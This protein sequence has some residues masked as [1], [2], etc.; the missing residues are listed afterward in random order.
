M[1]Q[2]KVVIA[3]VLKPVND[4]RMFE[5]L[6]MSLATTNHYDVNIIGFNAKPSKSYSNITFHPIFNFKRISISRILCGLTFYRYLKKI[7]PILIIIT[8][9]ELIWPAVIYKLLHRSKVIYDVQENHFRNL[10]FTNSFPK[11]IRPFLAF[12]VRLKEYI[13]A[14]AIDHFFLAEKYYP[15][16]ISFIKNSYTILENKAVVNNYKSTKIREKNAN[17]I[18]L[19]FSGTL[20]KS[21]GVFEAI[22]LAKSL[23]EI[24]EII[25]LTI[26]G[27]S[28]KN[29]VVVEIE[30]QIKNCDFIHL[31]G[32]NRLVDHNDILEQIAL[33][34]FGIINYPINKSTTNS[35][36]TKLY[37]YLSNQLPILLQSHSRWLKIC[38][39]IK[40]CLVVNF[41]DLKSN[42]LLSK[43]TTEKFYPNGVGDQFTWQSE[44]IKLA[45]TVY[46]MIF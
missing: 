3:S 6:G 22:K 12:F 20:A 35:T 13:T 45:N 36:P 38:E 2:K 25:T 42:E 28:P 43:M 31:I 33:S 23:H 7:A 14:P 37:E 15:N 34:D 40:S 27:Y 21:T 18:K 9:H 11:I 30:N 39:P 16:E 4:T 41:D 32:G 8:T 44:E 24:D 46:K 19:L 5:K 1:S 17:E 10:L 26:I 29:S